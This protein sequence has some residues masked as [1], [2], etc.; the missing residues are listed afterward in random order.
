[1]GLF[2]LLSNQYFVYRDFVKRFVILTNF[3]TLCT[4]LK[5]QFFKYSGWMRLVKGSCMTSMLRITLVIFVQIYHLLHCKFLFW[6]RFA[7]CVLSQYLFLLLLVNLSKLYFN[8]T[9]VKTIISLGLTIPSA[10]FYTKYNAL[11]FEIYTSVCYWKLEVLKCFLFTGQ[12]QK[13]G[14]KFVGRGIRHQIRV[15]QRQ[16]Y[17][18]SVLSVVSGQDGHPDAVYEVLYDREQE[19]YEVDHLLDDYLCSSL[20]FTDV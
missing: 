8:Y 14:V 4:F 5:F 9:L 17:T 16:C 19:L 6:F 3:I 1:M 12:R 2:F 15:H 18:G 7:L 20:T 11:L 13:S 10:K